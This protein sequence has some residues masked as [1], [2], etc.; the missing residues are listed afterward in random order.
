ML[1]TCVNWQRQLTNKDLERQP[2]TFTLPGTGCLPGEISCS[3]LQEI[4]LKKDLS[5]FQRCIYT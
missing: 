3:H 1:L 2:G 4:S 5:A